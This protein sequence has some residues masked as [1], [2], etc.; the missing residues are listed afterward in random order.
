MTELIVYRTNIH[1]NDGRVIAG[2]TYH[3]TAIAAVRASK[4]GTWN[5]NGL[6]PTPIRVQEIAGAYFILTAITLED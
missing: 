4:P 1:D 5:G 2:S 6:A 3:R